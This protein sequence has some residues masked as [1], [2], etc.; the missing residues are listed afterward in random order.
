MGRL[1]RRVWR[2]ALVV[3]LGLSVVAMPWAVDAQRVER[4]YRIGLLER[5][6]PTTN[7]TNLEGFRQ[8]LRELG[9]VE[10]KNLVLEY[11]SA[12]GLDERFPDLAS[13]LVRLKVDLILSRGTLVFFNDKK[14]TETIPIV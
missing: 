4:L 14:A 7:A 11:R 8:G 1:R 5:T 9:Y 6:S 3:S 2:V 12:D 10:G 13:E